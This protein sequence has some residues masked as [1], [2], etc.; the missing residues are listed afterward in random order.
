METW[1]R[2]FQAE[3]LVGCSDRNKH[4]VFEGQRKGQRG[5]SEEAGRGV[6]GRELWQGQIMVGIRVLWE[7]VRGL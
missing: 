5:A 7:A 3:G 1:E 4:S 2:E 6:A